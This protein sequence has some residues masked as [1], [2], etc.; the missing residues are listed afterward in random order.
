MLIY[1]S[2]IKAFFG[3]DNVAIPLFSGFSITSNELHQKLCIKSLVIRWSSLAST[4]LFIWQQVAID[5][6]FQN[7]MTY[8]KLL[9][10]SIAFRNYLMWMVII[11]MCWTLTSPTPVILK[12]VGVASKSY[13]NSDMLLH[14]KIRML[15]KS[16]IL[17]WNSGT[18]WVYLFTLLGLTMW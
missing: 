8:I 16:W 13:F 9:S 15:N 5:L 10:L 3:I 14:M 11:W 7:A 1:I 6:M 12:A 17:T 18:L 4:I 2:E